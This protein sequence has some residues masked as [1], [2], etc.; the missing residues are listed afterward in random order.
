MNFKDKY[1]YI[2]FFRYVQKIRKFD[3]NFDAFKTN[4]SFRYNINE[5]KNGNGNFNHEEKL[6]LNV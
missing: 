5:N 4:T 2:V 6:K 3:K 1:I